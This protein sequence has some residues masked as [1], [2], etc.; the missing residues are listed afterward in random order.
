MPRDP[1]R[2]SEQ[3]NRPIRSAWGQRQRARR[4]ESAAA[5]SERRPRHGRGWRHRLWLQRPQRKRQRRLLGRVASRRGKEGDRGQRKEEERGKDSRRG[6]SRNEVMGGFRS[7]KDGSVADHVRTGGRSGWR[8]VDTSPLKPHLQERRRAAS[9]N[10]AAHSQGL[11][12]YLV[13][14]GNVLDPLLA[15][16]T[17]TCHACDVCVLYSNPSI[18]NLSKPYLTPPSLQM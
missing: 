14:W 4:R 7:S 16:A 2:K 12:R 9:W 1:P 8:T 3:A 17:P 6:I 18:L 15:R 5:C 11:D 10:S 13:C